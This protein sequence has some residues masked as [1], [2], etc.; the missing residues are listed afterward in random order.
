MVIHTFKLLPVWLLSNWAQRN[1]FS[2]TKEL[3]VQGVCLCI[4]YEQEL[5][6][7]TA[8]N[9]IGYSI[10]RTVATHDSCYWLKVYSAT[11]HIAMFW[12]IKTQ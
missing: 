7:A 11:T 6:G 1:D 3:A 4:S 5:E 12:G 8:W 2:Y 10:L 9:E